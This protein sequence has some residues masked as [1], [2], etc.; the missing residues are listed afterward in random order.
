MTSAALADPVTRRKGA[1][2]T[3]RGRPSARGTAG[4]RAAAGEHLLGEKVDDE[5]VVAG[6]LADEGAGRGV[7]AQGERREIQS[8][9]PSFSALEKNSQVGSASSKP[10][11]LCT[12]AAASAGSNRSSG[13]RISTISP[14]ARSRPNGSGGSV[15]VMSTISAAGGR[16]SSRKA[17]CS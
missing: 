2:R 10:E 6:K 11:T 15:R 16:W 9:W 12:S 3:G 14:A 17:I 1:R 7:T 8:G 13:I 5:P 4:G